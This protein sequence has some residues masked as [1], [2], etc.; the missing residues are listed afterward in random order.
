MA[1]RMEI[2]L[3]LILAALLIGISK[4]GLGGPVP[5]SMAAPILTLVM[6][7]ADAMGIVLPMLLFADLL[8]LRLYWRKWSHHYLR[9]LLPA[10]TVGII[11]GTL[12]LLI[13]PDASLRRVIGGFTLLM[14]AYKLIGDKANAWNYR[15][16][17]WHGSLAGWGS[18]FGAALANSGAAPF[19]AY[20]LLQP[21]MQPRMF[22]GTATLFFFLINALKVPGYLGGGVLQFDRIWPIAWVFFLIPVG[23]SIGYL[24]LKRINAQLFEGLLLILLALLGLI[25]LSS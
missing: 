14:I 17:A 3:F 11:S 16:R 21:D 8:A 22:V 4:G 10:A 9:L 20:M 23:F 19:T 18:A 15:P 6:P 24:G 1:G 13:L 12:V 25:L 5:G 7:A 2:T